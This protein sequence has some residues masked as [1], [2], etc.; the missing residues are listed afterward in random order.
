I[1]VVRIDDAGDQDIVRQLLRAHEYWRLKQLTVDLVIINEQGASYVQDVQGALEALVRSSQSKLGHATHPS[2][3]GVFI[4]RGDRLSPGDRL[5]LQ[6]A[7]RAV[8]LSRH[9]TLA[10]QVARVE[11]TGMPAPV[12]AMRHV[13][14]RVAQVVPPPRPDLEF[15]NGLGGV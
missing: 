9:G 10:E 8:L 7:A 11:R 15:F 2:H 1:V 14:T 6:A 12:R 3:G 4:L 5:A 13:D